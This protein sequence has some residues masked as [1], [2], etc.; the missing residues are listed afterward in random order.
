MSAGPE[1]RQTAFALAAIFLLG[2]ALR[3]WG[4][5]FGL[6]DDYHSGELGY[7]APSRLFAWNL[8]TLGQLF[9]FSVYSVLLVVEQRVLGLV[10]PLFGGLRL[11]PGIDL[12]A[13]QSA[14]TYIVLGR[15]TSGLLGA[16]TVF[17]VYLVG[18]RLWN[19]RVGLT[20]ALFLAALYL[21]LRQSHY[22]TPDATQAFLIALTVVFCTRLQAGGPLRPYLLAGV[23]GGLALSA[24]LLAWPLAVLILLFHLVPDG[25]PAGEPPAA[26]AAQPWLRRLLDSRLA[27]A[28]LAMLVS[29]LAFT[30][31]LLL[32]PS[33]Y[34]ATWKFIYSLGRL[35]G[36]GRFKVTDD[37]PWLFYWRWLRWG[38]GDLLLLATLGGVVLALGKLRARPRVTCLLAFPL[39]ALLTL[40]QPH[41]VTMSRYLLGVLV[42]FVLF[43]AGAVDALAAR[44]PSPA[45]GRLLAAGLALSAVVQPLV[46]G[47]RHDR[48]LTRED[49]RVLAKRWIE[50]NIPAGASITSE[51]GRLELASAGHPVALSKRQ[52]DFHRTYPYGLSDRAPVVSPP[53]RLA[54]EDYYDDGIQYLIASSFCFRQPMI[55]PRDMAARQAFYARLDREA[56]LVARFTPEAAGETP[57]APSPEDVYGPSVEL[58]KLARPGPEIR[59]YRL[60]PPPRS[61]S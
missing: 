27:F 17:P 12:A 4:S 30:P 55:D 58:T 26:A 7:L 9:F 28:A 16:A 50:Q 60:K 35:G 25:D 23:C 44:L 2:L 49:T 14:A 21:H 34:L 47:V 29:F 11:A 61:A 32:A 54:L 40:C 15:L 37:P 3:L 13:P 41:S 18:R 5:G 42:F 59:I 51:V 46:A 10:A 53:I 24:K 36:V 1:R 45:V 33:R 6:P 39:L 56:E 57:P 22:G 38:M 8:K 52:F 20:A 19:R 31:V 48:L 43:A